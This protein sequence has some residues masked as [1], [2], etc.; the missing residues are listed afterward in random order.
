MGV[1]NIPA[2]CLVPY[3]DA[4][5]AATSVCVFLL[6]WVVVRRSSD[7]GI[8]RGDRLFEKAGL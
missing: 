3:V 6:R 5:A 2:T 4:T 8:V 7:D 1:D